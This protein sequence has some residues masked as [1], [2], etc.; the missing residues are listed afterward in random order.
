M[1]SHINSYTRDTING[2]SPYDIFTFLYNKNTATA[3]NIIKINST[4]VILKPKLLKKK[5][6]D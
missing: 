1:M 4:D 6:K 2:K 3:L 5:K